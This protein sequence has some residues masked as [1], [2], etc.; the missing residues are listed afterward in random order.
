MV[1][2]VFIDGVMVSM[3]TSSV[4]EHLFIGGVMVSMF[5]SRVVT[6]EANM[7]TITPPMNT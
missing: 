5:D 6:L 2:H 1:E 3:F 7:L 4:V